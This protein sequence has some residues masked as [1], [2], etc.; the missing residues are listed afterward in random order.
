[1]FVHE[2]PTVDQLEYALDTLYTLSKAIHRRFLEAVAEFD[3]REAWKQ[4]GVHSMRDWLTF[5][6][7]DSVQT[8]NQTVALAYS[9]GERPKIASGYEDGTLSHDKVLDL[10]SFV[11]VEEEE[12]YAHDAQI[13]NAAQVKEWARHA[14]RLRREEAMRA[15]KERSLR[16]YWDRHREVLHLNAVLPGAEG[17]TVKTAIERIAEQYGPNEDGTWAPSTH[18]EADA[19]IELAATALADDA[20][21][22]RATVVVHV[23]AHELNHIHGMG[24]LEDGPMITSEV[25][26]RLA[27]DGRIQPVVDGSSGEPLGIGRRSRIVPHWLMRLLKERDRGC[28]VNACGRTF[29]LQAH[30]VKHWAHGGRTDLENLVLVCRRCHRKIHDEGF[31]LVR[32]QHGNVRV[33]RPDGRPVMNRPAPLRPDVKV[34]MLGPARTRSPAVRC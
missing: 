31:R 9:L 18:R 16:M 10:C 26:R 29:G 32:T 2:D 12:R 20:D 8:A 34:R 17:A 14:R 7:G 25:V 22:D 23:D 13:H 30:H 33:L 28:V 21:T 1:M 27:C 24:K 11:P 6:Y 15:A 19:L 4:D 3:R 5:R